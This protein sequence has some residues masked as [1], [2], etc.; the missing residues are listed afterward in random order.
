M[1]ISRSIHLL[2]VALFHSF[3][4]QSNS[5]LYICTTSS[6]TCRWTF[7]LFPCLDYC[8]QCFSGHWGP[9][10]ISKYGVLWIYVQEQDFWL[11]WQFYFQLF[12]KISYYSPQWL[13]QFTFTPTMQESSLHKL[14]D[15]VQHIFPSLSFLICKTDMIISLC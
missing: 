8:K 6:L 9:Y 13:Q 1:I 7:R 12:M 14:F 15:H 10:I 4:Q 11:I 5:P 3:L 2:Q